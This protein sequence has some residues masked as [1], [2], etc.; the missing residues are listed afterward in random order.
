MITGSAPRQCGVAE[1]LGI[2]SNIIS[3]HQGKEALD[4]LE[5]VCNGTEKAPN[6]ILLDLDMPVMDGFDFLNA[7]HQLTFPDKKNSAVVVLTASEKPED[8]KR[9]IWASAITC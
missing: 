9:A 1:T 2:F 6:L 4:Y 8:V 3:V 5:E 7:F